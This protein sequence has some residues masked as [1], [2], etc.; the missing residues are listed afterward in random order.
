MEAYSMDLRQRVLE[1]VDEGK[2]TKWEISLLF[3]VCPAWIRRLLQR[4]RET[5]S[6][7]P[8]Q[9]SGGSTAKLNDQHYQRLMELVRQTPDATLEE[10]RVRLGAGVSR[11]TIGRAVLRLGLRL[12]KSRYVPA[13]KTGPM[14]G[15]S[16]RSFRR[17]CERSHPSA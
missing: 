2:R 1:A 3:K 16:A 7:A 11:A 12:K 15:K 17:K 4:R 14:F 6:I 8:K 9:R 13:S 10:L 5:G